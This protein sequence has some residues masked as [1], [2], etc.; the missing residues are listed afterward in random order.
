ME[1]HAAEVKRVVGS[2]WLIWSP[3]LRE[4]FYSGGKVPGCWEYDLAFKPVV[5]QPGNFI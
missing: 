4:C 1:T 5:L 3:N 2:G